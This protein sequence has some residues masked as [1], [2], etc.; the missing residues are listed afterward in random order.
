MNFKIDLQNS[1]KRRV[2]SLLF[3][4]CIL[5]ALP[6]EPRF[7]DKGIF[8]STHEKYIGQFVWSTEKVD[9]RNPVESKFKSAFTME[10]S[11][12]GRFY[13]AQSMQNTI[14]DSTGMEYDSFYYF[15]EVYVDGELTE[16]EVEA[17][18]YY[19]DYLRRT[20]QQLWIYNPESSTDLAGWYNL[21]KSLTPGNHE[22]RIDLRA[23]TESG[24][25]FN[26]VFASGQFT[27]NKEEGK[28]PGYGEAFDA[29]ESGMIDPE[30]EENILNCIIKVADSY[31]WDE[32]F[33]NVRIASD[34]WHINRDKDTGEIIEKYIIA[35]CFA[36]WPDGHFTVQQFAFEPY[37]DTVQ[38]GGVIGD[39]QERIDVD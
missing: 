8:N 35:Y 20:T 12:Y 17:D 23:R 38:F 39:S 22:I 16:W 4:F 10:D 30:L 27:L 7:D 25:V 34:E 18:R 24:E 14:Y 15:Y 36:R 32:T 11:I 6:A 28:T 29:Y 5:A 33:Y 3:L 9:L 31:D 19:G 21:C 1:W 2:I 26:T 37:Y 13:L